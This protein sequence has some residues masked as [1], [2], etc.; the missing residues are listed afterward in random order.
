[1]ETYFPVT[2]IFVLYL[3]VLICAYLVCVDVHALLLELYT[4]EVI[5]VLTEY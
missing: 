3:Y 5:Y 4:V 2:H 1:M